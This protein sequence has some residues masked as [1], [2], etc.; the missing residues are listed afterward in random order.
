MLKQILNLTTC[1]NKRGVTSLATRASHH[2]HGP[3]HPVYAVPIRCRGIYISQ[4][5]NYIKHS[6]LIITLPSIPVSVCVYRTVWDCVVD[7]NEDYYAA[8]NTR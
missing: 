8:R 4:F 1:H 6:L 2:L 3:V 5:L 7:C